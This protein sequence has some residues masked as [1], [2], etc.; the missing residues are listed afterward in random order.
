MTSPSYRQDGVPID[1]EDVDD[2]ES[3]VVGR[4]PGQE[5]AELVEDVQ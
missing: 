1:D 5:D 4:H 3:D 2:R